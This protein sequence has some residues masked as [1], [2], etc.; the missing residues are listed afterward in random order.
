MGY[1]E[2]PQTLQSVIERQ[3]DVGITV[4]RRFTRGSTRRFSLTSSSFTVN[5][6]TPT[7]TVAY[8]NFVCEQDSVI[9]VFATGLGSTNGAGRYGNL[10]VYVDTLKI[11]A[12]KLIQW[13]DS[14]AAVTNQR[15]FSIPNSALGATDRLGGFVVFMDGNTQFLDA[16]EHTIEMKLERDA[17]GDSCTLTDLSIAYR[18]N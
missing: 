12:S 18:I 5:N 2:R 3:S 4:D 17:S 16:G 11:Y 6:T 7:L 1:I 13:G 14:G 10:V 8:E 15:R 9:E